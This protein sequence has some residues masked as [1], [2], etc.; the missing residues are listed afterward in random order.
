MANITHLSAVADAHGFA[1]LFPQGIGDS[2]SVPG[3]LPTPAQQ[4]GVDDV[5]FVHS[6]LDTVGPKFKLET[7][8]AVATGIS[9]GGHFAQALGCALADH[10]V[11]VVTVAA[12]LPMGD[13]RGCKPS[14]PLSILDIVGTDDQQ[15]STFEDTLAFWARTD[16]CPGGA[17]RSLLPDV[18][19]DRTSVA[20]SSFQDCSKRTEVTGYLIT[21]GGHAWPGGEALGS[22]EEFG[23]TS[24]QFD[25]SELIWTFLS[26]HA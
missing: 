19:H 3:G 17:V 2:W 24:K 5:A 15:P 8:R 6:L 21:G 26:R 14:R 1:V 23:I 16:K 9:N 10:L 18:A 13:P 12:P 11:G 22:T 7:S 4:A 20:I 25:A